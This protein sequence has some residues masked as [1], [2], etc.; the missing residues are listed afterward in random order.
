MGFGI[1][2]RRNYIGDVVEFLTRTGG[3]GKH[4]P[5]I[6]VEMGDDIVSPG[7]PLPVRATAV[8]NITTKFREAFEV[9]TPGDRWLETTGAGDLILLDGNAAAAS[10]L[11]ISKDP[12]TPD[13]ITTI[14]CNTTFDVPLEVAVGLH[15]SQRTY[16]QELAVELISTE[17][18]IAG[19]AD[20]AISSI[21]QATT[22]LT[23]STT[24]PHNLKPG[25]RIGIRGVTQDSRLN[26]PALVVASTPSAI[27]FTATAGPQGTI[28]SLS[29]GPYAAGF[30]Y[31]RPAMSRAPNGTSMVFESA[32]VTN[33]SFYVRSE[34]GDV[35]PSGTIIG[36]HVIT[37]NTSASVQAINAALTY[38]FQPTTE[39]RLVHMIDGIQW[40]DAAV[41]ST[42][43]ASSRYKRT[44]VVPDVSATYKLRFRARNLPSLTVPVAK[45]VSATKSGTTTATV[46]TDV[47]HG[48]TTG[49]YVNIYGNRDSTNFANL[50]TA[51]VV[52]SVVNA[53]TFTIVWGS[54]VSATGYGGFVARV[55]GQQTIQ[56]LTTMV[57]QSVARTSNIVAL[58]G[59]AAWSG[60]LI[61][62]L[63]NLHGCRN[64]GNGGDVGIDGAYRVRDI[65]TTVIYLEPVGGTP[66]GVDITSTNCGGAIIRRTD[67][68]ISYVRIVDFDRLRIEALP[69]PGGDA[70][71]ALPV[72]VNGGGLTAGLVAGTSLAGDVGVQLRSTGGTALLV[73][74][75]LAAAATTNAT[76][77]KASAGKLAAVF[78]YNAATSVRYLKIYNKASPPAVGTDV[79]VF[80]LALPPAKD[81][82]FDWGAWGFIFSTGIAFAITAGGGDADATACAANDVVGLNVFCA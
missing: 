75:L 81:F 20:M 2:S 44:Q 12:L 64:V 27:Q 74:R 4:R 36:S 60:V 80:T 63:V 48:L 49:D 46:V 11:V 77:A 45:I 8:G 71:Q 3:D 6:A 43:Q 79:P 52:A 47:A 58:T 69:R 1:F 9:Y 55:N 14:D 30:V 54:A 15:T 62:D 53:T 33:G 10:Y 17:D 31:V 41:D 18:P 35:L 66:T 82:W 42:S 25:M 39:Y 38:A 57:A 70:S 72:V 34:A 19:T 51:T 5:V 56:G 21:Q 50:T 7:N 76:V 24:A 16:G 59:S 32:T 23:V 67:I 26:Y 29:V 37:L 68:R 13:T 65:Q 22:T 40:S 78:G 73:T 28:P 61:G